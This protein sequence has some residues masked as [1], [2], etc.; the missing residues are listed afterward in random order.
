MVSLGMAQHSAHDE[1]G[2]VEVARTPE[3]IVV[4][5]A[6][7][8]RQGCEYGHGAWRLRAVRGTAGV[9][10]PWGACHWRVR[11]CLRGRLVDR[12]LAWAATGTVFGIWDA[13]TALREGPARSLLAAQ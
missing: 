10:T 1:A 3:A 2:R 12:V 8:H 5:E 13:H 7:R 11:E 4:N 6:Q 9:A